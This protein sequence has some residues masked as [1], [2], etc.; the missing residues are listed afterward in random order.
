[1]TK[2]NPRSKAAFEEFE[3]WYIEHF[4]D[5]PDTTNGWNKRT[6][7][8]L[9][10]APHIR[11]E[12]PREAAEMQIA[13]QTS[14]TTSQITLVLR[15]FQRLWNG[16]QLFD[17]IE[18]LVCPTCGGSGEA[19]CPDC[20]SRGHLSHFPPNQPC[21]DCKPNC[22]KCGGSGGNGDYCPSCVDRR[23]GEQRKGIERRYRTGER[24]LTWEYSRTVSRRIEDRRD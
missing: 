19:K 21:P 1:M 15:I 3:K 14:F 8:W 23:K 10:F 9:Y 17:K 22:E 13:N 7:I 6:A 11:G 16:E 20:D 24:R 5:S 4:G 18:Q 12:F 2:D